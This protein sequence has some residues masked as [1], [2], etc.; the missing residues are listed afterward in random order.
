MERCILLL[1][2]SNDVESLDSGA[3]DEIREINEVIQSATHRDSFERSLH[4]AARAS[5]ITKLLL[6]HKPHILH[7]SGHS[8]ETEGLVL[9]D[10][11]GDVARIRCDRLVKLI[12]SSADARLKLA[13]FSFC[14]SEACATAISEK[15][16][17]A[18]GVRG[19]IHAE[20][21]LLFSEAFYEALASNRS[22]Q[23]ALDNARESLQTLG[24]EGSEA[25]VLRVRSGTSAEVPFLSSMGFLKNGVE[26]LSK[27]DSILA[28]LSA[29]FLSQLR[30]A[31]YARDENDVRY[32]IHLDEDL[33]VHRVRAEA[34]TTEFVAK[35]AA[36]A[37]SAG[38]WL[39]IVGDAGHGKSSLLWYL[40]T[41]LSSK[42]TF[43]VIP[44]MAQMESDLAV[45]VRT[46]AQ[47]REVQ[48][49]NQ[50]VVLIDTLDLVVGD[51]DQ[52]L[53]KMINELT[54]LGALVVTTSRKQEAD[55]L[56]RLVSSNSRIEL[57]RYN[58]QEAQQAI[59]ESNTHLLSK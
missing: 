39:S 41:D 54:A 38:K 23:G 11:N 29:R 32:A 2:A 16:P 13:F 49:E 42:P 25:M 35:A 21:L 22:V 36:A 33:Y 28:E 8:R 52:R 58:S 48:N 31:G 57:R 1:L 5:D 15:V 45:A 6:R 51:D 34:A 30:I 37:Q 56:G 20:S 18:I 46:A 12:L 59:I 50:L 44:F 19:Q 40:F 43:T 24:L 14:Y 10:E 53:A 7:I 9:E 26:E 3:A 4:P 17:Y 55:Q 27:T 47:A